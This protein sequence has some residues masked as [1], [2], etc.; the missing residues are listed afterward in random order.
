MQ[1]NISKINLL[2]FMS[3]VL[4]L[5]S[6]GEDN[7]LPILGE[8]V[9]KD[10]EEVPHYIPDFEFI[11]QDSNMISNSDLNTGPYVADFFFTH[12]PSICPTVTKEMLKI[13]FDQDE[14]ANFKFEN[15]PFPPNYIDF[16]DTNR[17][18]T[19]VNID[20]TNPLDDSTKLEVGAEARLFETNIDYSSSGLSVNTSQDAVPNNG[21]EFIP[22][23]STDFN[24]RLT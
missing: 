4:F 23:P 20:Y 19:I 7:P 11:N 8:L 17:D 21:D 9:V 6:C 18:Q 15:I 13:V 12:C 2:I 1:M 16:V 3:M 24:Y 14:I 5:P 22:T 10:G